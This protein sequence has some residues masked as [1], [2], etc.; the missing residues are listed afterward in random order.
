MVVCQN[1]GEEVLE[2]TRVCPT[3]GEF[4]R[5]E[6]NVTDFERTLTG[7]VLQEEYLNGP[8]KKNKFEDLPE[9]NYPEEELK[10][11]EKKEKSDF[12]RTDE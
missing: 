9:E 1:C 12:G 5:D 7:A 4:M 10:E 6:D 3:C 11:K 2:G 8:G